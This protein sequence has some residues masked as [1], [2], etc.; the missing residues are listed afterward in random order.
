M[1]TRLIVAATAALV[2]ASA[3]AADIAKGQE[4]AQAQCAAC[5]GKDFVSPIDP[6][7]PKL[8][9]QY[10][11]YLEKALRDYQTGARKNVIMA[12]Q[13]KPLSRADI[14]NLAAYLSSLPGPLDNS[15]R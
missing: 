12:G 9:G 4:L 14:Q 8:A 10:Y 7:Y 2:A 11:D 6:T 13:A 3:Q 1:K 15:K 5:H